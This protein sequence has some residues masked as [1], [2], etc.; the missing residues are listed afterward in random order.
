M[1]IVTREEWHAEAWKGEPSASPITEK[2]YTVFHWHGG[3]PNPDIGVAAV[4]NV[5]RSH[6]ERGWLGIG[7]NHVVDQAGV[8]S[9]GRGFG[10]LPAHAEG[11]N[12]E[13]LGI[14]ILCGKGGRPATPAALA[15][16][17]WLADEYDRRAGK[18]LRRVG[19]SA[20]VA[21]E[22]PGPQIRDWITRGLPI[23]DPTM[24]LTEQ[25]MNHIAELARD[26]ILAATYGKN[27]DGTV[28]KLSDVI[29]EIRINVRKLVAGQGE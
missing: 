24:A 2:L 4:K 29:G 11:H 12:R 17:A 16:A 3:V 8:I 6:I 7:Y 28:V 27:P 23:G 19:H 1:R 10:L 14:L 20:I 22:C 15:S 26:K 25:E 13:S 5:E 18:R 21:T 9:A